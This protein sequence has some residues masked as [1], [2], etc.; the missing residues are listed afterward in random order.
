MQNG[1]IA[2]DGGG[3]VVDRK[4]NLYEGQLTVSPTEKENIE[5]SVSP[6]PP[7]NL[8]GEVK[9]RL[10]GWQRQLYTVAKTTNLMQ[11]QTSTVG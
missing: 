3:S 8:G 4:R 2:G 6:P 7:C 10:G 1:F 11:E 9:S 5:R